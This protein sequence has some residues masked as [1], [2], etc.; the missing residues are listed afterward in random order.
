MATYVEVIIIIP[1][2]NTLKNK[3]SNLFEF[4]KKFLWDHY[5]HYPFF[6]NFQININ[7]VTDFLKMNFHHFTNI[8]KA[9]NNSKRLYIFLNDIIL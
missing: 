5:K 1:T 3:I 4:F 6:W 2:L 9:I 8:K 7:D